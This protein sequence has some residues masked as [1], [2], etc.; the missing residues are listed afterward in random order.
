MDQLSHI[1]IKN[2]ILVFIND[3]SLEMGLCYVLCI[4]S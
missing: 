3:Y 2:D 1:V 4:M